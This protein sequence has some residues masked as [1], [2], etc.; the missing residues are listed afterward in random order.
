ME[1]IPDPPKPEEKKKEP[2]PPKKDE[3]ENEDS[4]SEKKK[5]K[6]KAKKKR[7]DDS[8]SESESE[9]SRIRRKKKKR[10]RRRTPT[11]SRSRSRSRGKREKTLS[12]APLVHQPTQPQIIMM[13]NMGGMGMQQPNGAANATPNQPPPK[14]A[15]NDGYLAG[16]REAQR[17]FSGTSRLDPYADRKYD[18]RGRDGNQEPSLRP[19]T[20]P[21]EVVSEKY[22][23]PPRSDARRR[24]NNLSSRPQ[25]NSVPYVNRRS[26]KNSQKP[27]QAAPPPIPDKIF[28]TSEQGGNNQ[29]FDRSKLPSINNF[30]TK[31]GKNFDE[32][33]DLRRRRYIQNKKKLNSDS[34]NSGDSDNDF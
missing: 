9:D 10:R 34:G 3:E 17:M 31:D 13:P 33:V 6:K 5:K 28:D 32:Q 23:R 4:D 19:R 7:R 2:E 21:N 11:S 20:P 30:R 24:T 15:Y 29:I 8:D 27:V 26:R 12:N 22:S 25:I 1:I 14:E 16:M 18:Q